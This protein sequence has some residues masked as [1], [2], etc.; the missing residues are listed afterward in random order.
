MSICDRKNVYQISI[1]KDKIHKTPYYGINI[2][3]EKTEISNICKM[4]GWPDITTIK[5]D[6]VVLT[7]N[8]SGNVFRAGPAFTSPA[9]SPHI[10]SDG[11]GSNVGTIQSYTLK[12]NKSIDKIHVTITKGKFDKNTSYKVT[13]SSPTILFSG[14]K[15]TNV[16]DF[17]NPEPGW[18]TSGPKTDLSQCFV[19]N[20]TMT[21]ETSSHT[22]HLTRR[23]K[24]NDA[25][26][27]RVY[28]YTCYEKSRHDTKAH[29]II[30]QNSPCNGQT[31]DN[32]LPYARDTMK[33]LKPNSGD[34]RCDQGYVAKGYEN[35]QDKKL[36]LAPWSC[37]TGKA[38]WG[39]GTSKW[40]GECV[41]DNCP[42]ITIHNS[43]KE[44]DVIHG[45]LGDEKVIQCNDGYSFN[46]DLL[47]QGGKVHCN[48]EPMLGSQK[49]RS[50]KNKNKME[51]FIKDDYLENVCSSK[52]SR[53]TCQGNMP[54]G[55]PAPK[56]NP[57]THLYGSK[58]EADKQLKKKGLNIAN[59]KD[60]PIGCVWSP[61]NDF[62]LNGSKVSIPG[63]CHF[64]KKVDIT[65][66]A[67]PICKAL[68]CPEKAIQ[69]S[70]RSN[71]GGKNPLPGPSNGKSRGGNCVKADG[72]VY[73]DINSPD[74][75]IAM[76]D[77]WCHQ[78]NSCRTCTHDHNCNWCGSGKDSK[79]KSD[80]K[81]V[82]YYIHS[83]KSCLNP[84]R[85]KGGGT[86]HDDNG[87]T[88]KG[89]LSKANKDRTIDNCENANKCIN[90][91][92]K[93]LDI[94][95][96]T[97]RKKLLGIYNKNTGDK[98]KSDLTNKELC[99]SHNNRWDTSTVGE[100]G[101]TVHSCYYRNNN[102]KQY[103][104]GQSI[105]FTKDTKPYISIKPWY[106]EGNVLTDDTKCYDNATMDSCH[107]NKKCRI[108]ENNFDDNSIS[109]TGSPTGK[110]KDTVYIYGDNKNDCNI[111][112]PK[113]GGKGP[114]KLTSKTCKGGVNLLTTTKLDD[115][116]FTVE[117]IKRN[118]LTKQGKYIKT[119]KYKGNKTIEIDPTNLPNKCK[120]QYIN[121]DKTDNNAYNLSDNKCMHIPG[122]SH[123][124]R[125]ELRCLDGFLYCEPTKGTN[126]GTDSNGVKNTGK[127]FDSPVGPINNYCPPDSSIC[128]DDSP[129]GKLTCKHVNSA[130]TF[131]YKD[132]PGKFKSNCYKVQPH[133]GISKTESNSSCNS[134]GYKLEKDISSYP[135][136][137]PQKKY[138]TCVPKRKGGSLEQSNCEL[139]S[140]KYDNKDVVHWGKSCRD[141]GVDVPLKLLCEGPKKTWRRDNNG[142]WNCYDDNF[143]II[144]DTIC[145]RLS[146]ESCIID[147]P[148]ELSDSVVK[149]ACMQ[150]KIN[151]PKWYNDTEFVSHESSSK[152][153][154]ANKQQ[155]HCIFGKSNKDKVGVNT[156]EGC[157]IDNY[158]FENKYTFNDSSFC[159]AVADDSGNIKPD[160]TLNWTGGNIKSDQA[161]KWSSACSSTILSTCQVDCAKGYGGGG[162]YVCGYNNHG[163]DTCDIINKQIEGEKDS[164]KK[165]TLG[166]KCDSKIN[167]EYKNGKCTL[168]SDVTKGQMEWKGQE[169]Y[170]LN[171][172]AFSHGIYN[173]P[174]LDK[175]FPPLVRIIV[176]FI[177]LLLV[178]GLAYISGLTRVTAK[179]SSSVVYSM[180]SG[181]FKGLYKTLTDLIAGV[182]TIIGNFI[183]GIISGSYL[184]W[185]SAVLSKSKHILGLIVIFCV[186]SYLV[187]IDELSFTLH[188]LRTPWDYL[189]KGYSDIKRD[190]EEKAEELDESAIKEVS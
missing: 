34:I 115:L 79:G 83:D 4:Y 9:A 77:C 90:K 52:S 50:L 121:I 44:W 100:I 162:D 62:S 158:S 17:W 45:R 110:Y 128:A 123:K 140:K 70:N 20:N 56:Y 10:I 125:K 187:N 112:P 47:H 87:N 5:L 153:E 74:P 179:V 43:D 96:K 16:S 35:K 21:F 28:D 118:S 68:N 144:N 65:D 48:Y 189:T 180:I 170:R 177:I 2:P 120:L 57:Y 146:Q 151:G 175:F 78:H 124:R 11:S 33:L 155:G 183:G 161:D 157:E 169:C 26:S 37:S 51:W 14:F 181:I 132:N 142:D 29:D 119:L 165:T 104:S 46:H 176:L 40:L 102:R 7:V 15:L 22:G 61:D 93:E 160:D 71:V 138:A 113:G 105:G 89:W 190:V 82:C 88:K 184:G 84:T 178:V 55:V 147:V 174:A 127:P 76:H 18:F 98:G 42:D 129:L 69:F 85:Q 172:D 3:K 152:R 92:G 23:C 94:N 31:I 171:N 148:H 13:D 135:V 126:C 72:T 12:A 54:R 1:I 24:S 145:K 49:D 116:E 6:K 41:R 36:A 91:S 109:W 111:C 99:Y 60:I 156:I 108:V 168:K 25:D 58:A 134:S 133:M 32:V 86:C 101:N 159:P 75:D 19:P 67:E 188:Y 107:S 80:G 95:D 117:D 139:L 173:Y 166:T 164:T 114:S 143:S 97:E 130:E 137:K 73:G 81:G 64:R 106:C 163:K 8:P 150:W 38:V 149:N 154:Y 59:N 53:D 63:K 136:K 131:N 185:P 186:V 39:T 30:N 182:V 27:F 141:K 167:C 103:L 122:I 66:K